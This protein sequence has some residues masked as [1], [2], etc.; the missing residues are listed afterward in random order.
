MLTIFVLAYSF[1]Q[2][3]LFSL[4]ASRFSLLASRLPIALKCLPMSQ[5]NDCL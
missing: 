4:L 1:C 3:I 5:Q 2:I